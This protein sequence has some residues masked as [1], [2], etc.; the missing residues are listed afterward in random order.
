M[1]PVPKDVFFGRE[2]AES[3]FFS[4][5]EWAQ[6]LWKPRVCS[7]MEVRWNE[8]R[9]TIR[10]GLSVFS[11]EGAL[12]GLWEAVGTSWDFC[13]WGQVDPCCL[14]VWM[15]SHVFSHGDIS[16]ILLLLSLLLLLSFQ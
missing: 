9:E 3:F 10:Q 2:R 16:V 11:L 14:T 15:Q 13:R 8:G 4:H 5:P 1:E 12:H 6:E 7:R